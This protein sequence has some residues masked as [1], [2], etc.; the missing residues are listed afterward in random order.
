M[1]HHASHTTPKTV[2]ILYTHIGGLYRD[3]IRGILSEYE[4]KNARKE[5]RLT[6]F[7]ANENDHIGQEQV[8]E[9]LAIS[10]PDLIISLGRSH[11]A[12]LFAYLEEHMMVTPVIFT[13]TDRLQIEFNLDEEEYTEMIKR[14]A[15]STEPLQELSPVTATYDHDLLKL[16]K[17]PAAAIERMPPT[18]DRTL[19]ALNKLL[20][21][22]CRILVPF[23]NDVGGLNQAEYDAFA[24]ETKNIFSPK[25]ESR[26]Q[27]RQSKLNTMIRKLTGEEYATLRAEC[28]AERHADHAAA[29][30][31]NYCTTTPLTLINTSP[32]DV[33]EEIRT[34]LQ[35]D[36]FDAVL[37]MED[38][39]LY[40]QHA[41]IARACK[42]EG[43][44]FFGSTPHAVF[45]GATA[46]F[47]GTYN[48]I[49]SSCFSL[50]YRHL[51]SDKKIQLEDS[52]HVPFKREPLCHITRCRELSIKEQLLHKFLHYEKLTIVE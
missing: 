9:K 18:R 6:Y 45:D 22:R 52:H 25:W 35:N 37:T 16:Y 43:V 19:R 5:V 8:I 3:I 1:A 46:G 39:G 34:A 29:Q 36:S 20:T 44:L 14:R 28:D 31:E 15:H 40:N 7:A 24:E 41:A 51:T 30:Q 50:A 13:G 49:G 23:T 11:T 4:L 10:N 38:F 48:D 42:K 47:G 32:A 21:K 17:G 12:A 33:E 26:E 2:A 27:E